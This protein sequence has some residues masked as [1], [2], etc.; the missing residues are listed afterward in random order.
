MC[1][2]AGILDFTHALSASD[3][4]GVAARMATTLA[5]RGPDDHG[6]WIDAEAGVALGHRRLS[7]VDLSPEGH[8][9]MHSASQRHVLVYNGEIY[10]HVALRAEL[11]AIA[12]RTWRGHSD[13]E[14]VLA[15]IDEWGIEQAITRLN[16]MFAIALWDR[17]TRTL[18]LIRDR[19]GEKPLYFGRAGGCF[20]FASELDAF[21]STPGFDGALDH[22][23]I[24]LYL[25]L[26]YVPAPRSI[27]ANIAKL[28]PATRVEVRN[29][30]AR[31]VDVRHH[32]YWSIDEVARR[33]LADPIADETDARVELRQRLEHGIADRLIA[34]VPLGAFL[35]GGIDSSLIVAIMQ[36]VASRPVRT[37][38]I[39][40]SDAAFDEAPAARAVARHLGSD[41][42]EEILSGEQALAAVPRLASIYDEPFADAS[43]IP[44]LLVSEMA[45]KHVTVCLSG[46]GGDE[47]FAGYERYARS[48][49]LASMPKSLR[50][51]ATVALSIASPEMLGSI[52][53]AV[54]P[55]EQRFV[56][57]KE[58]LAK[59]RSIVA[60][61]DPRLM[62]EQL[63]SR[64]REEAV[65]ASTCSNMSAPG[66][67]AVTLDND[68]PF[69]A[70][71]MLLDAHTYLPDDILV[72]VD[73]AAM[74]T[75]L[76]T[77]VPLLD[78]TLVEFAWRVPSRLKIRNG[79][80]KHLLRSLLAELVPPALTER[81]KHGF[82]VPLARWLRG[83]LREWADALLDETTMRE[84]G[85]LD[86]SR[87]RTRWQEHLAGKRDAH[88][89]LWT[90]ISLQAWLAHAH[91]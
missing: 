24:S 62:Y 91:A 1:G 80:G 7:I 2:I 66:F 55:K 13:T 73:R 81:P 41:H 53:N 11:D 51:G 9:P 71:M 64:W 78:H 21:R 57:A 83:P 87:V 18:H 63:V 38:T 54:L 37:F 32:R 27:Y 3:L 4:A 20:A 82:A 67:L 6:T 46:D 19:M 26:G 10:N 39:G 56:H 28:A 88:D 8:Q 12:P 43:A 48:A 47:L 76:E 79:R 44:T 15:A 16:G 45:R 31:G 85:L 30:G 52:A 72:K 69:D 89:E 61:D 49:R 90:V 36:R 40:F 17:A 25:R 35:S 23:A 58:K 34:D 75:S 59:L 60:V 5:H 68:L 50:R 84:Q 29:D 74:S 22:A 65:P 77:R 42:R 33:G 86:A 14:V 70:W